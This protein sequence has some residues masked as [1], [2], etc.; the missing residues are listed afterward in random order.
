MQQIVYLD[1]SRVLFSSGPRLEIKIQID[2]PDFL[3]PFW[4]ILRMNSYKIDRNQGAV[5]RRDL[6]IWQDLFVSMIIL[7]DFGIFQLTT[8]I[9]Q[10]P[11]GFPANQIGPPTILI[12]K[13]CYIPSGKLASRHGKSP[14]FW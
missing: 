5:I 14:F 6:R 13:V 2:L 7:C 12:L 8:I 9:Y 4:W 10:L 1:N 11:K 3:A